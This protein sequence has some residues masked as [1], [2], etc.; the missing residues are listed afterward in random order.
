MLSK[1]QSECIQQ[2]VKQKVT[3]SLFVY[4]FIDEMLTTQ[5][6]RRNVLKMKLIPSTTMT[7]EIRSDVN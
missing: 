7:V 6:S 4:R 2:D 5:V 3:Y 1:W